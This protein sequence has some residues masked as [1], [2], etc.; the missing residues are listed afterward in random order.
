MERGKTRLVEDGNTIYEID[1]DCMKRKEMQRKKD[2][3]KT[4][5]KRERERN[6]LNGSISIDWLFSHF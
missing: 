3:G 5:G 1:L 6:F 2:E 4:K